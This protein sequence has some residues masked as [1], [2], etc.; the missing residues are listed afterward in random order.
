MEKPTQ[1]RKCLDQ[2]IGLYVAEFEEKHETQLE[3]WIADDTTG[4]AAFGDNFFNLADIVYDIDH[5]CPAGKIFSWQNYQIDSGS[6]VNFKS[7]LGG[8]M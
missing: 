1:L 8:V 6:K 2:I 4:V 3:Y 7:Y 5:G